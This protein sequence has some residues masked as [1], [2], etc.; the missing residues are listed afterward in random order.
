MHLPPAVLALTPSTPPLLCSNI[1]PSTP[2]HPTDLTLTH[3]TPPP[4]N[5]LTLT[6]Y[7]PPTPGLVYEEISSFVFDPEMLSDVM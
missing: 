6:P 4:P 3:Y 2:P 7:A 1:N 5:V